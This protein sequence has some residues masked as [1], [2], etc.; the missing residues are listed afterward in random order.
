MPR[1]IRQTAD[2]RTAEGV[3]CYGAPA[4]MLAS[5]DYRV[6]VNGVEATVLHT[7]A[8]SFCCVAFAGRVEVEIVSVAPADEAVISPR[9]YGVAHELDRGSI[10]FTLDRPRRLHVAVPQAPPLFFFADEPI[11]PDRGATHFFPAGQIHEVDWLELKAGE[12][13]HIE[14]GAVVRGVIRAERAHGVSIGGHGILDACRYHTVTR[15]ALMIQLD[16]CDDAR[17][18]DLVMIHPPAWM[19]RLWGCRGAR[20]ERV[21]QIGEVPTSDGIDVVSSHDTYINDCFLR[22]NDDCIVVKAM[23]VPYS[24]NV[25]PSITLDDPGV[26]NLVAEHCTLVNAQAGN[27]I[28][29]GHELRCDEVKDLTFR[30]LDVVRADGHGGVFTIHNADQAHVHRVLYE[31]IRVE[32]FFARLID[33]WVYWSKWSGQEE[34]GRISDVTIRGVRTCGDVWFVP[35]FLAGWDAEHRVERVTIEDFCVGEVHATDADKL[36][37]FHR[38]A[39]QARFLDADRGPGPRAMFR[40]TN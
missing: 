37:L 19:I 15:R 31:D 25:R 29:I 27:A 13:V 32:H 8:A 23:P 36:N 11:E 6:F 24:Q 33:F 2:N 4:G 28:E 22:N 1:L 3:T 34:R 10:R 39:D 30:H 26:S 40:H 12:T 20:V 5:D 38:H 18:T 7:D 35:S 21:K 9:S 14:G 17:V 16:A